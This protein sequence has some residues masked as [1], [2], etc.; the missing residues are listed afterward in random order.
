MQVLLTGDVN[1]AIKARASGLE[2]RKMP[3]S[4]GDTIESLPRTRPELLKEFF[5][6]V[7]VK[8]E[9][10]QDRASEY[11]VTLVQLRASF[12]YMVLVISLS[13]VLYLLGQERRIEALKEKASYDPNLRL[14]AMHGL[15]SR[16][17]S[18]PRSNSGPLSPQASSSPHPHAPSQQNSFTDSPHSSRSHHF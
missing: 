14:L 6:Q 5:P 13:E 10:V 18:Q 11:V 17:R 3:G 9:K 16:R 12:F 2:S 1:L 15:G 7:I 4:A 8:T